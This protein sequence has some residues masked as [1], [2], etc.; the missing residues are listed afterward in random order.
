MTWIPG[1]VLVIARPGVERL[2]LLPGI[3]LWSIVQGG[4]SLFSRF[5]EYPLEG[6]FNTAPAAPVSLGDGRLGFTLHNFR[7][8]NDPATNGL[9]LLDLA[10]GIVLQ[11]NYLPLMQVNEVHWLQD[12]SGALVISESRLLFVP[13]AFSQI[14]SLSSLL[15]TDV[16]CFKWLP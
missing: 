11:A 2:G 14:Y 5:G 4:E 1:D 9:F 3:E 10:S 6:D 12:G 15:G 13:A 7:A 8:A 16:C